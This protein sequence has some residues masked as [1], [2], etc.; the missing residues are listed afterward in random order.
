MVPLKVKQDKGVA[1]LGGTD[2][3][4]RRIF[5]GP[6]VHWSLEFFGW[7]GM[8]PIDALRIVTLNA[9]EA[10]GAERDLGSLE[11]G[12]FADIVLLDKN[13]LQDLANSMSIWRVIKGGVVFDPQRMR[14]KS[15]R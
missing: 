9:A 10:V 3:R 12:K 8:E 2:A 5:H 1:L 11:T 7:G 4:M 14:T 15:P 6:S 13:P